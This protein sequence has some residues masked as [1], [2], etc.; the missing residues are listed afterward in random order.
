MRVGARARSPGNAWIRSWLPGNGATA[1]GGPYM[2]RR[3]GFTRQAAGAAAAAHCHQPGYSLRTRSALHIQRCCRLHKED[4]QQRLVAR[5]AD[6][7]VFIW[8]QRWRSWPELL[9]DLDKPASGRCAPRRTTKDQGRCVACG[10][11]QRRRPGT[12]A[13]GHRTRISNTLG[14][15]CPSRTSGRARIVGRFRPVQ[16][17]SG[18]NQRRK[19]SKR[20]ARLT[21]R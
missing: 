18:P 16:Q 8:L 2:R 4:R 17:L 1:G 9:A 7:I 14:Q 10:A 21:T 12:A 15:F 6:R 19:R 20:T 11:A 5:L 3:A 13:G